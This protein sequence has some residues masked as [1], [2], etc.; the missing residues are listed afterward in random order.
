MWKENIW[1]NFKRGEAYTP[2]A[3]VDKVLTDIKLDWSHRFI[4]HSRVECFVT[5][6]VYRN[7]ESLYLFLY[8]RVS[9]HLKVN[10]SFWAK[11]ACCFLC[12]LRDADADARRNRYTEWKHILGLT[13]HYWHFLYLNT[14][15]VMSRQVLEDAIYMSPN[16]KQIILS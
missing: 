10:L 1:L 12:Q 4:C 13:F 5:W 11:L 9:I 8:I 7:I 6:R 16:C 14:I 15:H 3:G 2:T